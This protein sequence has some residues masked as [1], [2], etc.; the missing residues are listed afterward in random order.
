[1]KL[2]GITGKSG[3]GKTTLS[4]MLERD[5]SIG[6]IHLDEATNMTEIKRKMPRA[7]VDKEPHP[8]T[9]GENF[10]ILRGRAKKIRNIISKNNV[11]NKLYSKML[12]WPRRMLVNKAVDKE[13]RDGRNTIIIE[14]SYLGDFP[15]YN[16]LDY[17]IELEVPFVEREERVKKRKDIIFDKTTMVKRDIGFRNAQRYRKKS[18]KQVDEKINNT[19]SKEN[20]QKIA[21]KIYSEQIV[22]KEPKGN[23]TMQDKYGGY[24]IITP[25]MEIKSKSE[26]SEKG[27]TTK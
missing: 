27:D 8:N 7:I 21:D 10:M 26:R 1:M 9:Q 17:L 20:L 14:G 24:K 13:I 18:N 12:Y 15:I 2:I 3:T 25:E 11:L 16:K 4:R 5:N 19:G 23:E 22:V 6:V